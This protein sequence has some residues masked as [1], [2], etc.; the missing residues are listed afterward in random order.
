MFIEIGNDSNL[1]LAELRHVLSGTLITSADIQFTIVLSGGNWQV[2]GQS[3]P[4]SMTLVNTETALW[5]GPLVNSMVLAE[6]EHYEARIT[7]N[8]G[9]GV[10]GFWRLPIRAIVREG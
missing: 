1:R 9:T 8:A 7:A 6:G 5:V 3:W 10:L 2:T 4:S